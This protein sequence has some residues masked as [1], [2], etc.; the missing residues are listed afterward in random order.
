M[1]RTWAPSP[2]QP[3]CQRPTRRRHEGGSRPIWEGKIQQRVDHA[4]IDRLIQFLVPQPVLHA[5]RGPLFTATCTTNGAAR[6]PCARRCAP[7]AIGM[8][9]APRGLVSSLTRAPES[10][11]HV[12]EGK[13]GR[14]KHQEGGRERR[15]R[16]D[17]RFAVGVR[18]GG[19]TAG[20][21][22]IVHFCS[23]GRL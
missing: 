21:L 2:C 8:P 10:R 5:V 18:V 12:W 17:M 16:K 23:V 9:P 4:F 1:T 3:L 14:E 6:A 20:G 7:M 13:R 22:A 19:S 11:R 15:A